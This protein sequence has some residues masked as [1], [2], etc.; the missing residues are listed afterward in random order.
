M[1]TTLQEKI[2]FYGKVLAL[3]ENA[4]ADEEAKEL[5]LRKNDIYSAAAQKEMIEKLRADHKSVRDGYRARAEALF[6]EIDAEIESRHAD[7]N[8]NDPRLLT[9]LQIISV[10]SK[11]DVE[12]A[13]SIIGQFHGQQRELQVLKAA[14]EKVG[15]ATNIGKHIYDYREALRAARVA[16]ERAFNAVEIKNTFY[17]AAVLMRDIARYEGCDLDIEG[18]FPTGKVDEIAKL[19][20]LSPDWNA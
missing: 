1:A 8:L 16:M 6:D 13:E 10:S 15:I 3:A 20:G 14:F 7:V 18:L 2:D 12:L 4:R 11:D 17:G 19:M 5:E 9:A